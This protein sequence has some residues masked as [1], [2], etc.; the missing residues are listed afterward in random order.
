MK[1]DQISKQLLVM[2]KALSEFEDNDQN[3]D[4]TV[5]RLAVA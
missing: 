5:V 4:K 1:S 2:L 3:E